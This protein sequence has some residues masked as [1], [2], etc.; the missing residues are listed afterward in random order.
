[1]TKLFGD[2]DA[3]LGL[4][5]DRNVVV[6]G[7]DGASRAHALCLRD[8]GVDL[9]VGASSQPSRDEAVAEG[10]RA[11]PVDE[12]C[13]E[14]D[15]VAV[16]GPVD[17][18]EGLRAALA[19]ALVPG[20]VL[21][22]GGGVALG[23]VLPHKGGTNRSPMGRPVGGP[24]EWLDIIRIEPWGHPVELREQYEVGRGL[25]AVLSVL[26]DA[27]GQ[28]IEVGLGY[29]RGIG[30]T[31]AGVLVCDDE[32]ASMAATR[33]SGRLRTEVIALV[34]AA[35]E[36]LVQQGCPAEIAFLRCVHDLAAFGTA[37]A[38]GA[39]DTRIF[40]PTDPAGDGFRAAASVVRSLSGGPPEAAPPLH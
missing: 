22:L 34:R 6:I 19:D 7:F 5:Q 3:D 20:D 21:V 11:V 9:R 40:A 12:A 14:A 26:S 32:H 1:M 13:E 38:S 10:L 24:E 33:A 8:S 2:D 25:A 29:A 39:L 18:P 4:V 37:L 30:A 36:D 16:P 35:F 23:D 31:R 27:S 17:D 28:A 15:L